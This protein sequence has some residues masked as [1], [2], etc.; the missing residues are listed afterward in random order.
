MAQRPVLK[1]GSAR[2]LPETHIVQV[3]KRILDQ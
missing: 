2:G 3:E 1:L